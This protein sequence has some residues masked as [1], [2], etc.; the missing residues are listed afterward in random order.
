MFVYT[1]KKFAYHMAA[2]AL[3]WFLTDRFSRE[4]RLYAGWA[5]GA[6]GA[7]YLLAAWFS[8]LKSRDTDV[9]K[10]IRRKRP[11]ETPYYLRGPD[12]RIKPALTLNN[13]R[14]AFDDDLAETAGEDAPG[15]GEGEEALPLKTRQ[16]LNALAWL[17]VGLALLALSL[18]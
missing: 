9:M 18:F 4:G 8:Y 5:A 13:I 17:A 15:G 14:H 12:K 3:V 11:P 1:L 2:G 16:K 6:L 7:M 10:L